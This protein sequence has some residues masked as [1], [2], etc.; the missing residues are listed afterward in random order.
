MKSSRYCDEAGAH[1]NF[2]DHD[3]HDFA[4]LRHP[5]DAESAFT[6]QALIEAV[7]AEKGM[8]SVTVLRSGV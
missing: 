8:T 6:P 5:L 1:L 7:R 2:D 3:K 4:L